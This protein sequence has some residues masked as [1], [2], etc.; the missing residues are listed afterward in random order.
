MYEFLQYF[1]ISYIQF[2]LLYLVKILLHR[3]FKKVNEKNIYKMHAW[4]RFHEA[5]AP[6]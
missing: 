5:L 2:G 4:G 1:K 3:M 6:Y